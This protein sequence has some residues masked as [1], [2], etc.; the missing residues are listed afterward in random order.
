MQCGSPASSVPPDPCSM[1]PHVSAVSSPT[2]TPPSAASEH[3]GSTRLRK[4]SPWQAHSERLCGTCTHAFMKLGSASRGHGRTACTQK[5]RLWP[6]G[7][8]LRPG[9]H[10][11]TRLSSLPMSLRRRRVYLPWSS[12]LRDLWPTWTGTRPRASSAYPSHRRN[13]AAASAAVGGT[14]DLVIK[15]SAPRTWIH[16]AAR[17][18][19]ALHLA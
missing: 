7:A 4:A 3:A 9:R 16:T 11:A 2:T 6:M 8:R 10:A 14:P 15:R 5:H 12:A 1:L 17:H 19:L 13:A 18:W